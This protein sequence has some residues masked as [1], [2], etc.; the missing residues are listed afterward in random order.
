MSILKF[1]ILFTIIYYTESTVYDITTGTSNWQ[2]ILS[3]LKAG[4][5]AT[6][7]QGTY[8][9]AGSGYFQLTLNGQLTQPIIIQGAPNEARPIIQCA[10]AGANVQNILN[11]QGSNYM[12]KH[13]AFTKGSRGLRLGPAV[14]SNA[15]F[16]DIYIYD[17]TGTAFSANDGGNE[18]FNLTLQNSEIKNTNALGATTGECVYF[19]C[20]NDG[21]RVRDSLLEHNYCHDTLGSQGGARAGFQVKSGSFNVIIRNNACYKVVGPCIVVYDDYNRGRNIITG[22]LAIEA[23]TADLG[24]QCTSGATVTNNIIINANLAGIGIIQNSVYPTVGYI[25]NVTI[26]HNTVYMSQADA[27]LRLNS[28]TNNNIIIANNV[29]YCGNQKSITSATN[30]AGLSIYNNAVNGPIG[31]PGIQANGIF[32]VGNN[33]FAD[34][35][36]LNFYPAV[37]SP[38]INTSG[39]LDNQPVVYDF[40]GKLRSKTKT[41]V[42]A[43]EFSSS[44]NPGCLIARNFKCGSSTAIVPNYFI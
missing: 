35:Q 23:G 13:L 44:T 43:Y 34:V 3:N 39:Y 8:T 42:G 2:S 19:G 38:L 12:L 26:N 5:I 30:L 18:Y 10:Q 9:T 20:V 17:T 41:T 32:T 21:C 29:L 27:C 15:I 28:V 4:D 24:I 37:G 31:A 36:N 11:V 33:V 22:N 7:H 40:N 14:T 25:R 1:L 16:D 6:I